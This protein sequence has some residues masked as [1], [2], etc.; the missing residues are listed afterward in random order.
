MTHLLLCLNVVARYCYQDGQQ[1]QQNG[2]E[3]KH[4]KEVKESASAVASVPSSASNTK[5]GNKRTRCKEKEEKIV[6]D[7][8]CDKA[9]KR[10][11]C[12]H[13]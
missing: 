12:H 11:R 1:Q 10:V 5:A 6:S 3:H 7:D 4:E 8:E 2:S 13:S 9:N